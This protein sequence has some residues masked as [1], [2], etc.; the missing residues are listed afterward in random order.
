MSARSDSA[1]P[2]MD[3][4][5][6]LVTGGT[7]GIGHAAALRLAG[8]RVTVL[9][10]GRDPD[11]GDAAQRALREAGSPGARFLRA[12]HSTPDGN[13]ALAS[14]VAAST[15][16]LDVLINNVGGLIPTRRLAEDGTELTLA[17]NLR[18]AVMT[19]EQVRPLLARAD[20]PLVVNL[21]SDAYGWF[22]GD[23]FADLNSDTG[24]QAFEA[25]ARAKLL[26]V[27]ATLGP[28]AKAAAGRHPSLR[29][30]PRHGV[31]PRHPGDDPRR[32]TDLALHLAARPR[33]PAAH[34]AG[35]RRARRR[36]P[37]QRPRAPAPGGCRPAANRPSR[38]SNAAMSTCRSARRSVASLGSRA[39]GR[40][41]N[42]ASR[43]ARSCTHCPIPR[44]WLCSLATAAAI[45]SS[46]SSHRYRRPADV[47]GPARPPPPRPSSSTPPRPSR[48]PSLLTPAG[49]SAMDSDFDTALGIQLTAGTRLG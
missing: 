36:P 30:Q 27:L 11:R 9:A 19:T 1:A 14:D 22:T 32:G 18:A 41:N 7:A 47:A 21:A 26:L 39:P 49:L 6:V 48:H 2:R 34:A 12:D 10:T 8:L 24:Y 33:G 45:S 17:P 25:Y 31:D 16:V 20:A 42:A 38:C 23:P 15:P 28:R 4:R 46:S 13:L 29:G 37:R 35:P 44:P 5:T 40:P 3:G 43:S